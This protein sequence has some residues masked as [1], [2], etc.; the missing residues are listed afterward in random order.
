MTQD[1]PMIVKVDPGLRDRL[2]IA[3]WNPDRVPTV[4]SEPSVEELMAVMLP[5]HVYVQIFGGLLETSTS[6]HAARMQA[7]ENLDAYPIK[8]AEV[9]I[10]FEKGRIL[11]AG[12]GAGRILRYYK[13]KGNDIVGVDYI[14]SPLAKLRI[15]DPGLNLGLC[16]IR[17]L[18]F[19]DQS[20]RFVLAFGL[21][22]SLEKGFRRALKE[23]YR[24][25]EPGGKLCAS[26][27]AD[28]LHTRLIDFLAAFE[29]LDGIMADSEMEAWHQWVARILDAMQAI[30]PGRQEVVY[31]SAIV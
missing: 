27:R 2:R 30:S 18:I 8:Y 12:C 20:F 19:R 10:N 28:N 17:N 23:T 22:H 14:Y 7:M 4:R 9:A 16:D 31:S 3:G 1:G 15:V 13:N 21:Y 25:L 29:A 24:V 5:K 6:E 26:F 11:E